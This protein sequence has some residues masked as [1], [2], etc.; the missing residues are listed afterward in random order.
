M[1]FCPFSPSI[2]LFVC[3]F[4]YLWISNFLKLG[5]LEL[6]LIFSSFLSYFHYLTFWFTFLEIYILG[7]CSLNISHFVA[8][9][10]CI[11]DTS[12]SHT[13]QN[14]NIFLKISSLY[15]V[16]IF[17]NIHLLFILQWPL[18]FRGFPH[19]SVDLWLLMFKV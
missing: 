6:L 16:S 7:L 9:Y 4:F 11:I 19:I 5:L 13:S 15:L 14:I 3:S 1:F 17:S 10:F 8:C 2:I 12:L 18:F